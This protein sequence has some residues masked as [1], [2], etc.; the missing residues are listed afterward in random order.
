[1]LGISTV[2][3]SLNK[4]PSGGSAGLIKV[5]A[6]KGLWTAN[7]LVSEVLTPLWKLVIVSAVAAVVPNNPLNLVLPAKVAIEPVVETAF[8]TVTAFPTAP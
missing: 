2:K 7:V 6:A 5:L 3:P 4:I 8:P 1:M